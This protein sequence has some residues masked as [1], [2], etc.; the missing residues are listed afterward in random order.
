MDINAYYGFDLTSDHAF[1]IPEQQAL[2]QELSYSDEASNKAETLGI[3]CREFIKYCI[4]NMQSNKENEI[5]PPKLASA[6]GINTFFLSY[7]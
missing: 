6:I 3:K 2:S 1:S 5:Q 7:D 4:E